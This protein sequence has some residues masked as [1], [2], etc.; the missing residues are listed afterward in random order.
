MEIVWTQ[1]AKASYFEIVHQLAEKWAP[2]ELKI[3][4]DTTN[5]VLTEIQEQRA[6]SNSFFDEL[7]IYKEH[8][9]DSCLLIYLIERNNNNLFILCFSST[10]LL[11]FY[12]KG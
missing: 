2:Y 7:E 11:D 3:F 5:D 10:M 9:N 12:R 1:L 4:V 8:I 6:I